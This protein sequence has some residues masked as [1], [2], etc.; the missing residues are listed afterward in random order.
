MLN[1]KEK[2]IIEKIIKN[3]GKMTQSKL[4][5]EFGEVNAFRI[6][7]AMR[8]RGILRREPYEKTNLIFLEDKFKNILCA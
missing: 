3:K 1:F 2:Q 4:S 5:S 8:R 7:E 6:I